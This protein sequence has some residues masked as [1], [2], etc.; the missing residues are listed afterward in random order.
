MQVLQALLV[1]LVL[2]ELAGDV[3]G[4]RFTGACPG[5][6]YDDTVTDVTGSFCR[7]GLRWPGELPCK[8][9]YL[10]TGRDNVNISTIAAQR[11]PA[12][13]S[14]ATTRLRCTPAA[15]CSRRYRQ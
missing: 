14:R 10:W 11:L 5:F 12:R 1:L 3:F 13:R 2:L 6:S 4:K 7:A 9:E 8:W 15:M